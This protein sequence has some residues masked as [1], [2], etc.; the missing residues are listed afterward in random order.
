MP[1]GRS[2]R[3]RASFCA[4]GVSPTPGPLPPADCAGRGGDACPCSRAYTN[5]SRATGSPV[6]AGGLRVLVAANSFALPGCRLDLRSARGR[7]DEHGAPPA[8]QVRQTFTA[9]APRAP[10]PPAPLP[11]TARERGDAHLCSRAHTILSPS[12]ELSSPRRG[13]SCACCGEFIRSAGLRAE[14]RVKRTPRPRAEPGVY[15][16]SHAVCGR[17]WVSFANPG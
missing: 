7:K 10:S 6:P 13:T 15:T 4:V 9:A 12:H 5:L 2:P 1:I 16:L 3:G 11:Q 14:W 17:G 8:F